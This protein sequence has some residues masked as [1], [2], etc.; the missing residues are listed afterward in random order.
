VI[1]GRKGRRG[2]TVCYGLAI[3]PGAHDSHSC[4]ARQQQQHCQVVWD[5]RQAVLNE[6]GYT[7]SAGK[8]V[9][10]GME[11]VGAVL[12]TFSSFR[13]WA[14]ILF[15]ASCEVIRHASI[16]TG[17]L[18]F[19]TADEWHRDVGQLVVALLHPCPRSGAPQTARQAG[20]R[21]AQA[22]PA[23]R[24]ASGCCSRPASAPPA[25]KA[26]RPRRGVWPPRV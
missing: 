17:G 2:N 5:L 9:F 22:R 3:V 26:A 16:R 10:A 14:C 23:D 12:A 15:V 21:L 6:L 11:F 4:T 20:Q 24:G 13:A 1:E 8:P 7:C 25:G 18:L 19:L